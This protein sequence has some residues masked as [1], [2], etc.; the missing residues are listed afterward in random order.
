MKKIAFILVI[1]IGSFG[2]V[3]AQTIVTFYTTMGSFEVQLFDTL[4]PI[5]AGNFKSL[6]NTKFYDGVIFHRIM[7]NFVIQGG[8]PTGTGSGGPG[9]SIPD[10]FDSTESNLVR[11]LSM[12]NAGP[13]TGGSQFFINMKDNTFLDYNK[14]PL[15]SAHPVFGIVISGWDTV[16][17][18]EAVPVNGQNRPLTD[19]VMDSVR[20]TQ[21]PLGVQAINGNSVAVEVYP[22]PITNQ[23]VLLYNSPVSGSV[24]VS[25]Y[26]HNGMLLSN[27]SVPVFSGRNELSLSNFNA[28]FLLS[29]VYLITVFDGEKLVRKKFVVMR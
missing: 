22:N 11:T 7:S 27:Q 13:N 6:V 25:V 9:Y 26:G 8:D 28:N 4:K 16:K 10:E 24:S 12:A 20:V 23:S 1:V 14:A 21:I 19:V 18:I 29:G 2:A 15:T 5:T 3:S 17:L